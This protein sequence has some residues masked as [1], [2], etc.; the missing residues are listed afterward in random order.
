M[1]SLARF[2]YRLLVELGETSKW[3]VQETGKAPK[4]PNSKIGFGHVT[5]PQFPPSIKSANFLLTSLQLP[6]PLSP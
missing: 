3:E 4:P 5:Y 6:D 1:S 2:P